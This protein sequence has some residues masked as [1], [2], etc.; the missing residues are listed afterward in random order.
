MDGRNAVPLQ[1]EASI[2]VQRAYM[3][4]GSIG[5]VCC[6]Q[7]L[8]RVNEEFLLV[9]QSTAHVRNSMRTP[10]YSLF[11]RA[12]VSESAGRGVVRAIWKTNIFPV[13]CCQRTGTVQPYTSTMKKC[14]L[15]S[16]L[17]E[18]SVQFSP[19]ICA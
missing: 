8:P 4:Q 19:Q 16:S 10:E 9:P 6:S 2:D 5:V 11:Q 15:Q 17:Q 12:F 13:S 7:K 14:R 1:T 3:Q 18:T